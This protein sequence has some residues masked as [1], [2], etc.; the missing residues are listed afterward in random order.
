MSDSNTTTES[1]YFGE[2][3]AT[4]MSPE[5]GKVIV[6]V[7]GTYLTETPKAVLIKAHA[8]TGEETDAWL[9]KS[10][11]KRDLV[12]T[13]LGEVTLFVPTWLA[14]AKELEYGAY[15]PEDWKEF[16]DEV[17]GTGQINLPLNKF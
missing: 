9:P 7:S 11:F 17:S 15:L 13:E 14:E 3:D 2:H 12:V 4:P 8:L 1:E 5:P 10:Q 16:E 6:I